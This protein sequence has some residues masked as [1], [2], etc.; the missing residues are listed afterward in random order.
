MMEIQTRRGLFL[1]ILCAMIILILSI[2]PSDLAGEQPRFYFSGMDKI[3][4]GIMYGTFALL[5]LNLYFKLYHF[6]VIPVVLMLMGVW[7]YSI[8]MELVQHFFVESR[9]A[10]FHDILANLAGILVGAALIITHRKF[11]S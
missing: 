11:R 4:H 6:K 8:I 9:S 2:L 1:T 5:V 7:G 3:I 10:E